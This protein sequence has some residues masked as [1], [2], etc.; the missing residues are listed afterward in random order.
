MHLAIEVLNALFF[1]VISF[2]G[3]LYHQPLQLENDEIVI[4]E[5]YL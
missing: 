4:N 3:F 1:S 2:T 5:P